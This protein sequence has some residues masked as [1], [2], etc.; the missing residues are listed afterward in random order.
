M[1]HLNRI[2]ALFGAV[3]LMA[4]ASPL[5]W[6]AKGGDA[7]KTTPAAQVAT[8]ADLRTQSPGTAPNAPL[9]ELF[10]TD[11]V[12]A[13][14]GDTAAVVVKRGRRVMG[15]FTGPMSKEVYVYKRTLGAWTVQAVLVA[16]DPAE[17]MAYGTSIALRGDT[18]VVGVD[19]PAPASMDGR[20]PANPA[21]IKGAYVYQRV[22]SNWIEA[23]RLVGTDALTTSYNHGSRVAINGSTIVIGAAG[24]DRVSCRPMTTT[25]ACSTL[26][27]RAGRL[28]VFDRNALGVW[29]QTASLT[30]QSPHGALFALD[31][32][33]LV[34]PEFETVTGT[35]MYAGTT[36]GHAAVYQRTAGR[37]SRQATLTSADQTTLA[38]LT[39]P[40][41]VPTAIHGLFV[42]STPFTGP[43]VQGDRLLV[44]GGDYNVIGGDPGL[45]AALYVFQ[46]T[47]N[48]WSARGRITAAARS[49]GDGFARSLAFSGRAVLV[50]YNAGSRKVSLF[51]QAADGTWNESVINSPGKLAGN[52]FDFFGETI[53]LDGG[54]ALV[55]QPQT[56]ALVYR[57]TFTP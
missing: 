21:A 15:L 51:A 49:T 47:G 39:D 36:I 43:A 12:A 5:A 52:S 50:N 37:W 30:V 45:K 41:N 29:A 28:Y 4:L 54:T 27:Q 53:A 22:G 11:S 48:T 31:G 9:T 38:Q 1:N 44:P 19:N 10:Q 25:F 18:L 3:T 23:T 7:A 20:T 42:G 16:S 2:C 34:V 46:R 8:E 6:A 57:L 40:V 24:G 56:R 32:N 33:T 55:T 13:V 35:G 17:G 26:E 14:S